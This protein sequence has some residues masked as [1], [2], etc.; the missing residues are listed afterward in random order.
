MHIWLVPLFLYATF[1]TA[2]EDHSQH[3]HTVAG[4]GT[5][6]FPTS[7]NPAAQALFSRGMAL[8]HSFGYERRQSRPPLRYAMVGYRTH[9]VSP[10]LGAALS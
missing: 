2:Q 7:C 5:V 6:A 3:Q 9:L 10:H 1:A 8:L 4:L